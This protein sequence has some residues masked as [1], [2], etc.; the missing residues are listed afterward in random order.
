M[1]QVDRKQQAVIIILAAVIVFTA[2]YRVSRW[3]GEQYRDPGKAGE[4]VRDGVGE[5]GREIVVHV[6]GAVEKPGVYKFSRGM[7]VSDALEK[8]VPLVRADV[9]GLNLAAPLKDGQKIVVPLK[10]ESPP[11]GPPLQASASAPPAGTVVPQAGAAS[12]QAG[13]AVHQNTGPPPPQKAATSKTPARINI[14]RAGAQELESLPGVGPGLAQRIISY[15]ENK[16]LFTSEED[17]KNVPGIG[18]KL[19]DQIK[20]RITVN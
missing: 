15:R 13:V 12:P 2:G 17:I 19:Y 9:Q 16:G 20:D 10:Q 1:F 6:S 5:S 11:A 4:I 18:E 3:Q 7:R 14:N 8:A